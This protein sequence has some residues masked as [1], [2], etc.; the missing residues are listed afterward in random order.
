MHDVPSLAPGVRPGDNTRPG[1]CGRLRIAMWSL[2]Q[3]TLLSIGWSV[4]PRWSRPDPLNG[5]QPTVSALRKP[6]RGSESS[7]PSLAIL[8]APSKPQQNCH[9]WKAA[10]RV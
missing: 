7:N 5:D 8:P 3:P 1:G 9:S 2:A 10:S 6:D 4:R